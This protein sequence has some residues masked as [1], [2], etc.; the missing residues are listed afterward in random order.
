MDTLKMRPDVYNIK[1]ADFGFALPLEVLSER[2]TGTPG[3]MAPEIENGE[4]TRG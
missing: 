1:L 2:V 3:Y 4:P